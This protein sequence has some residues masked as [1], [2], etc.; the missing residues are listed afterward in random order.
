MRDFS[1]NQGRCRGKG[2]P[3]WPMFKDAATG[4]VLHIDTTP[5]V[6]DSLGP[7][8]VK[9]YQSMCDRQMRGL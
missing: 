4:P 9:L 1:V 6:G 3:N 7:A 8:K 2:L 5:A